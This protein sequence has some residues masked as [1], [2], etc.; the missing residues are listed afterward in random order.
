MPEN[1]TAARQCHEK[2]SQARQIQ[3]VDETA[4]AQIESLEGQE[5]GQS[6]EGGQVEKILDLQRRI[7]RRARGQESRVGGDPRGRRSR[8][9]TALG[10][11]KK[12]QQKV[13]PDA[14]GTK[15]EGGK[16]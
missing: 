2:A 14:S 15:G 1:S 7:E 6:Q 8:V 10:E 3:A 9:G 16:T 5:A 13:A 12:E 11:L 4:G